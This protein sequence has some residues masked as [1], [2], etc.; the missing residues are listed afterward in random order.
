MSGRTCRQLSRFCWCRCTR[1]LE[2]WRPI[3]ASP[4]GRRYRA[5]T[6]GADPR[7]RH[8]RHA[9]LGWSISRHQGPAQSARVRLRRVSRA[10]PQARSRRLEACAKGL[11]SLL[12]KSG[13]VAIRRNVSM[14]LEEPSHQGAQADGMARKGPQRCVSR[15]GR[16]HCNCTEFRV[17]PRRRRSIGDAPCL[18]QRC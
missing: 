3:L 7:Q 14:A 18:R 15:E 17:S 6:S 11:D 5:G 8:H 10:I 9:D 16:I 13:P 4:S 12:A 1:R 2:S